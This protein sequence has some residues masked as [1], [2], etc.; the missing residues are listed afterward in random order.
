MRVGVSPGRMD[1]ADPVRPG[2]TPIVRIHG[3][4]VVYSMWIAGANGRCEMLILRCWSNG[5]VL[6]SIAGGTGPCNSDHPTH[7]F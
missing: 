6:A 5:E 4:V 2:S 3:D 1:S 7:S